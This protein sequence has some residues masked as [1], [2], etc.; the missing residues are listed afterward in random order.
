MPEKMFSGIENDCFRVLLDFR[1]TSH[2]TAMARSLPEKKNF[3][4][5]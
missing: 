4:A 1:G 3:V 5:L 2:R